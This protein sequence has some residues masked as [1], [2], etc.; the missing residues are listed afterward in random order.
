MKRIFINRVLAFLLIGA[1]LTYAGCKDY[2][3]DIGN[4][5]TELSE[6]AAALQEQLGALQTALTGAQ[7]E[8]AA[9]TQKAAAAKEAREGIE[10]LTVA[11]TAGAPDAN[12]YPARVSHR[13]LS[14]STFI[15]SSALPISFVIVLVYL[16]YGAVITYLNA[17]AAEANLT[18]AAGVFFIAY[19]VTML[20]SRPF[21]GK[22]FDRHGDLPVITSG[23]IAFVAG[24]VV[25]GTSGNGAML[26]AGA[27]LM[28]YGIGTIQPSGLTL[29]VRRA[30]DDRFDVA[31]STFF[32]CLDAAIGLCPLLLGWTVPL[33]GFYGIGGTGGIEAAAGRVKRRNAAL[34]EPDGQD[35]K[36]LGEV[37]AASPEGVGAA[38]SA[39]GAS[40][41]SASRGRS[42]FSARLRSNLSARRCFLG[43]TTMS[44]GGIS[45]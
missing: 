21:T 37:H 13:K 5:Q 34:I 36:P 22:A 20:V 10:D 32:I 4:V 41:S 40:E 2:D 26:L 6:T 3:D 23:F 44:M 29:A 1:T 43:V 17:F 8:A 24:M 7:N 30:A 33:N 9:A 39:P 18:A 38:F 27:C 14:L 42:S 12:A 28:G 19:A 45:C 11:E 15:E 35:E 31:N 25:I 16:G